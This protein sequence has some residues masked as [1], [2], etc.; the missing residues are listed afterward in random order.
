LSLS[1]PSGSPVPFYPIALRHRSLGLETS[2]ER[3]G[4]KRTLSKVRGRHGY[5]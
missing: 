5:T 2:N 1:L 4:K 3:K